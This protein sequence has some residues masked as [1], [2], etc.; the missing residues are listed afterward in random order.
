MRNLAHY[1][2]QQELVI[3]SMDGTQ[4]KA[5]ELKSKQQIK[6]QKIPLSMHI[7]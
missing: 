4:K 1:V 7:G 5:V 6:L 3:D 2:L